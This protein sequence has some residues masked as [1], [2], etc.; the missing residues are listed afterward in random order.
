MKLLL[1][2]V[3]V[4]LFSALVVSQE[5]PVDP[6]PHNGG[7]QGGNHGN[8]GGNHGNQGGNHH[9]G[10]HHWGTHGPER[11][12]K[13]T[14]NPDDY[15]DSSDSSNDIICLDM[16]NKCPDGT[17]APFIVDNGRCIFACGEKAVGGLSYSTVKDLSHQLQ[18]GYGTDFIKYAWVSTIE[19]SAPTIKM[20]PAESYDDYCIVATLGC[21]RTTALPTFYNG[22]R[23]VYIDELV[24]CS[25]VCPDGSFANSQIE[26]NNNAR[27]IIVYSV[28]YYPL[29]ILA[30]LLFLSACCCCCVRRRCRKGQCKRTSTKET[31]IN[32]D[33]NNNNNNEYPADQYELLINQ[34]EEPTYGDQMMPSIPPPQVM[35]MPTMMYPPM[36]PVPP[37]LMMPNGMYPVMMQGPNGM[38]YPVMPP[39]EEN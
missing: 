36:P 27:E 13:P 34:Q 22:A 37:H 11:P 12:P 2:L 9:N 18:N 20:T 15:D 3:L 8:Q 6:P 24:A 33:N 10:G 16:L 30:G 21:D 32:N 29:V 5:R 38:W 39:Q 1:C 26:C 31:S 14:Q 35:M 17:E 4:L 28:M 25:V 19:K 23:V 7:N